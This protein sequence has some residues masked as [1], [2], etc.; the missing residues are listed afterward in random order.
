MTHPP[1]DLS[2]IHAAAKAATPGPWTAHKWDRL[3]DRP[4]RIDMGHGGRCCQ[5][6]GPASAR[7]EDAVFIASASP[8][9]VMALV[10]RVRELERENERLLVDGRKLIKMAE[11]VS[12]ALNDAGWPSSPLGWDDRAISAIGVLGKHAAR[13]RELEAGLVEACDSWRGMYQ[14]EF[15]SD[16]LPE[17][18]AELRALVK[19]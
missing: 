7:D 18:Y 2:A 3:N 11:A 17:G 16:G 14:N 19:P 15:D 12:V 13:I 6:I 4:P 5:F 8:S 9:V 10:D 1:L